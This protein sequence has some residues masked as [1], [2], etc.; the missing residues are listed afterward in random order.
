MALGRRRN[1]KPTSMAFLM[2]FFLFVRRGELLET[3][4]AWAHS[5]SSAYRA[6]KGENV[7]TKRPVARHAS[8]LNI[9][10]KDF[11]PVWFSISMD[12][13]IL[14]HHE[15]ATVAIQWITGSDHHY[16]RPERRTNQ[17]HPPVQA[18]SRA[19]KA[20]LR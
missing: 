7:G 1:A 13:G 18:L 6:S 5:V 19:A 15:P 3:R 8:S 10:I 11:S 20:H 2:L 4:R 12:T 17:H 9:A 16:V 14:D